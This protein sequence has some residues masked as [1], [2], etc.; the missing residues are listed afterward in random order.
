MGGWEPEGKDKANIYIWHIYI[1]VGIGWYM[2]KKWCNIW[3]QY[4]PIF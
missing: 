4:G 3:A 1:D 2:L